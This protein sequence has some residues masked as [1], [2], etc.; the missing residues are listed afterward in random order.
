MTTDVFTRR[1]YGELILELADEWDGDAPAVLVG[2]VTGNLNITAKD[3]HTKFGSVGFAHECFEDN[4][5]NTL[6]K[7]DT[8]FF[9]SMLLEADNLTE[10][11]QDALNERRQDDD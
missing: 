1:E 6:R 5:V 3:G 11:A 8:R 2:D 7:S 4:G 10:E 9:G